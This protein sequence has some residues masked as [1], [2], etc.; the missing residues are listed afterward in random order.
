MIKINEV[1]SG[2]KMK[3]YW[4]ENLKGWLKAALFASVAVAIM[5]SFLFLPVAIEGSSMFPTFQQNDQIIVGTI[6]QIERFDVIVFRDDVNRTFVKRVIGLPGESIRYENDQLFVNDQPV[7]ESFL[8]NDYVEKAGGVWTSNFTLES[9]TGEA[10]I[11][12]GHYFVLGDNRRLSHDS[13]YYGPIPAE[14]IVGEAIMVYYPL[15]RI[16]VVN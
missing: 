4:K 16:S 14:T 15:P 12:E 10:V 5:K 9:L 6:H 1:W 2:N 13:R 7:K 11:P 3:K 8:N